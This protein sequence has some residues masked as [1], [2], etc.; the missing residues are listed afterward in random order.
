MSKALP[1]KIFGKSQPLLPSLDLNEIQL[2]SYQ[3]FVEEGLKELFAESS[4]IVDH[5][6]KEL[7]L[8][9]EK[10]HFDE[11]KYDE[12]TSRYKD[13][14]YEATLRVQVKLVNKRTGVAQ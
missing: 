12:V 13:A 14:T 8:Y 2:K 4:P 11:P 3:W 7:E 6:G 10:Y 1:T 5:T 9:F